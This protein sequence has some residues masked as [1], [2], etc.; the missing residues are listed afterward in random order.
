MKRVLSLVLAC[1]SVGYAFGQQDKQF[2]HYMFDRMSYNPATT[3]FQGFCGTLL[4]RNQWDQVQDAPNTTLFNAQGNLQKVILGPGSFGAG[5]SF[6]NDAIG[7]QHSNSLTVNA[8][9]HIPT[10]Y[11]TL[12]AGIGLGMINVGF[13]PSWIPPVTLP[14]ADPDINAINNKIG[15]TGFDQNFGLFWYGKEGYYV[16]LS[17]THLAPANLSQVSFS[18]NRHYYVMGGYKYRLSDAIGTKNII[19]LKPNFLLKSDGATMVFD[20]NLMADIWVNNASFFWGAV[21][22]RWSDAIALMVGYGFSPRADI[23]K[24]M[25]KFGYS[26][27]IMTNPLNTYGKGTHELMAN[28][29]M[30]PPPPVV[31]RSGNPFILQ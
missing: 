28:Y 5:I 26:F 25:F 12:S 3:G 1:L 30:F 11:G 4:Y 19:D 9:Y 7:F 22:Y 15:Q 8:A 6:V 21:S 29:C 16:G 18:V 17:A 20:V 10:V 2:T 31:P 23:K 14:G 24:D 27:D 13:N